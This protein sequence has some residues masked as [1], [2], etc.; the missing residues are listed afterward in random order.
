MHIVRALRRA[1][2]ALCR[3]SCGAFFMIVRF[4]FGDKTTVKKERTKIQIEF[5]SFLKDFSENNKAI[6]REEN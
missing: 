2:K 4:W 5:E 3:A 1:K 6:Q